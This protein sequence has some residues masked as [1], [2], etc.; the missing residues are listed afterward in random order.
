VPV[1]QE[2]GAERVVF[3]RHDQRFDLVRVD[4]MR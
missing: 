3:G 4:G 1:D 2:F